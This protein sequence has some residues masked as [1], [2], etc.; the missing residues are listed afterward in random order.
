MDL[1]V[2]TTVARDGGAGLL[3]PQGAPLVRTVAHADRFRRQ[4][5]SS[6]PTVFQSTFSRSIMFLCARAMRRPVAAVAGHRTHRCRRALFRHSK[7]GSFLW[8]A[9]VGA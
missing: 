5:G 7:C 1:A 2:V 4:F 9:A 8:L 3:L 6:R